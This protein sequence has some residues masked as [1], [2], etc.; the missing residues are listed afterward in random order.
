MLPFAEAILSGLPP[1]TPGS[2]ILMHA[3]PAEHYAAGPLV[4]RRVPH[5]AAELSILRSQADQY[6][7]EVSKAVKGRCI[8]MEKHIAVG[9]PAAAIT[10]A[11]SLFRADFIAMTTHGFSGFSRLF[12]GSVADRVLHTATTPL[13]LL[14][15]V[16][17]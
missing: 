10:E 6:L 4:A 15:P 7:E 9:D 2:I 5:T 16:Q 3:L 1:D 8:S 14:K 12:L 13:L 17:S 11:A